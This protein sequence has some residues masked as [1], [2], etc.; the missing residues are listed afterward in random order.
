[1]LTP[2][3]V[4]LPT[5]ISMGR[6]TVLTLL[7]LTG[8]VAANAQGKFKFAHISVKLEPTASAPVY[9]LLP[10]ALSLDGM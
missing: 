2:V 7:V 10:H 5:D 4:F 1:M 9:Q 3:P 6:I 8:V